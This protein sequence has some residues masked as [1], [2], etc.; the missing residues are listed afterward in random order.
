MWFCECTTF[1]SPVSTEERIG[2]DISSFPFEL[3]FFLEMTD[4]FRSAFSSLISQ[5][6]PILGSSN[7]GSQL[8]TGGST[9]HP[10]V[11]ST[12]DV[13][14]IKVKIRSLLAEGGYALVFAGQDPQGN[15]YALKRQLAADRQAADAILQ[16]IQ[17]LKELNGHPSIVSFCQASQIAP[18][19]TNHGRAEFLLLTELCSGG[20]LLNV[21]QK[22]VFSA[23]Q[24]CKIFHAAANAV[25]HMHD[26]NPPITH[27]DIKIENLLFDSAGFV[28]LCDFGSATTEI[29]R[30]DDNW[31]ALKRSQLE[32]DMAKFTTP[33]YRAPEILDTYQ[34]FPIGPAQDVW[35]LGCILYYLCYRQHPFEDSAKLRIINAKFTL[36]ETDTPYSIFHSLIRNTLH[37]NPYSRPSIQD[38][39]ER[40][41]ALAFTM[42]VDVSVP[43]TDLDL[44]TMGP[45]PTSAAQASG[46][47]PTP[48]PVPSRSSPAAIAPETRAIIRHQKF[49]LSSEARGLVQTVQSTYGSKGP[50]INWL[51]GRLAISVFAEDV[52][53]TLA[54]SAEEAMRTALLEG[55][56]RKFA[57]YNL[58]QRKLRL[59][60]T[61][62]LSEMPIPSATSGIPP[63]LNFLIGLCRNIASFLT[64]DYDSFVLITG[65][66]AQCLFIASA[67]LVYIRIAQSAK[68]A[69]EFVWRQREAQSAISSARN[70]LPPSYTRQLDVLFTVVNCELAELRLM[71]HNRPVYLESLY[72]E[73][74]PVVNRLRTGC[75]PFFEVYSAGNKR[76]STL[77]EYDQLRAYELSTDSSGI[78]I[79]LGEVPVGEDVV[80]CCYHA[81]WNRMQNRFELTELDR[82]VGGEVSLAPNFRVLIGL[83]IS[84]VDRGFE[85][86][87][88]QPIYLCPDVKQ[89]TPKA[90]AASKEDYDR[91]RAQLAS[92]NEPPCHS[93]TAHHLL[94]LQHQDQS[95]WSSPTQTT[96]ET[97]VTPVGGDFFSNLDWNN[98]AATHTPSPVAGTNKPSIIQES[99]SPQLHHPG[100]HLP[101]HKFHHLN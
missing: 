25:H 15:W 27:R 14:G 88:E 101:D 60:Y 9:D 59:D 19:Q 52:P 51:T 81:R 24:I 57:V 86:G 100:P 31:N 1:T 30:P 3:L 91:L 28:K 20:P 11:G 35:A 39:C 71:I 32:E 16:E 66:E 17:F 87:E 48:S 4:I 82:V 89:V 18:K 53:E 97:A 6:G 85:P 43:L 23:E 41:D 75:R 95:I 37:P 5:A 47:V 26:R 10:L 98:T 62:R 72:I 46:S 94:D 93:H 64:R 34:N 67:V 44:P 36:P 29:F 38:L 2:W 13:G 73:P 70:V 78:S 92:C 61:R 7:S 84:E 83:R 33:M 22:K 79:N 77:K 12:V 8:V 65:T 49:L 74:L 69:V 56:N 99:E 68:Q 90:I 40:I 63:T 96:K 42:K 50:D 21:L 58:S 80:V 54:Y 55:N 45:S 76:W